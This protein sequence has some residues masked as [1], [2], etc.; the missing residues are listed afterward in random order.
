MRNR[1]SATLAAVAAASVVVF[2]GS[3]LAQPAHP[4]GGPGS[5]PDFG[6]L[7]AALK[8]QLNLNTSQQAM[9][10]AAVAQSK[11]AREAGR[12]NFDK[13]RAQLSTELAKAEPDLAA[14]AAA[15]DDAQ[16][17]NTALRKQ[18]RSQWL[19]IYATFT[20]DQ[21][22]VVKTALLNRVARME[23]FREKMLERHGG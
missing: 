10:D 7:F 17:A 2:A 16:A 23:K 21:K 22:A 15:A 4:H 9:W 12:A 8:S 14:V 5:G 1:F 20:P 13:V 11:S 19:A 6:H 18:V 3:A